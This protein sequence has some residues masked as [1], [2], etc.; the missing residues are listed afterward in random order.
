MKV[1]L[2]DLTFPEGPAVLAD[3]RVVCVEVRG[4]TIVGTDGRGGRRRFADVGGGPNGLA[5]G[6]DGQAYVCNNGGLM[7]QPR[8]HWMLPHGTPEDYRGGSIQK[9]DL[10]TGRVDTLYTQCGGVPLKG[11]NDL[12]FDGH[13]GFWFTDHGKGRPRELDRRG[14]YYARADG[15][16]IRE[17]IFPLT[18]ANGIG[19]SPDGGTLYVAETET[20]RLWAWDLE[21]PGRIAPRPW[22][23]SPNG[24]RLLYAAPTY[25]RFDSLA[26]EAD[27]NICVATIIEAGITV[28][29]PHGGLV[30][31]VP[32]EGDPYVT[33]LCFGGTDRRTAY[34]T[35]SGTG[36]LVALDWPRAGLALAH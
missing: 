3:G 26:M 23:R 29:S 1:V 31:H 25:M 11:P 9:V 13:G 28:V 15:S 19:L 5:I 32:I 6:P 17:V 20:A 27:G 33:N 4:G 16:E 34:V 12:V 36:R 35:L 22:P 2:D 8:G 18:T 21:G 30:E 14:V 24:G 7:W 10:A